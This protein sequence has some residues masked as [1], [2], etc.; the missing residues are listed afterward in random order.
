MQNPINTTPISQLIQ[1]IKA[2]ELSQ[3]KEVKITIQQARMLNLALTEILIKMNQDYESMYNALKASVS[4]EVVTVQLD[5]GDFG[6][7]E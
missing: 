7:T 4:S 1:L 5:G 3:S 2:A 6:N